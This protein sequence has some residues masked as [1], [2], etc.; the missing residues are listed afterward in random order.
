MTTAATAQYAPHFYAIAGPLGC[1]K[2]VDMA[3]ALCGAMFVE[4]GAP[5]Q[6]GSVAGAFGVDTFEGQ[7]VI[8][9][10]PAEPG[11]FAVDGVPPRRRIDN[12][13]LHE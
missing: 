4:A 13:P 12:R 2:G 5:G 6:L 3:R 8:R 9:Q 7:T 10:P 1:G 11:P